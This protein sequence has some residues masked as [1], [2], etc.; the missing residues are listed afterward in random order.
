MIVWLKD[1]VD[2]P[3]SDHTPTYCRRGIKF[4]TERSSHPIRT[5]LNNTHPEIKIDTNSYYKLWIMLQLSNKYHTGCLDHPQIDRLQHW[6]IV[7]KLVSGQKCVRAITSIV[8]LFTT[9]N[10]ANTDVKDYFS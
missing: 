10:M 4:H 6:S 5:V 8:R 1:S 2:K 7:F 9:K 3:N